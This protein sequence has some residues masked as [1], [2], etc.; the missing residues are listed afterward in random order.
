MTKKLSFITGLGLVLL[1]GL[2]LAGNLVFPA[3]GINFRWWEFW[4]LW[5]VIVISIG[6]L[7]C[8]GPFLSLGNRGLGGLFIPGIPI[9]VTGGI[10]AFCSIFDAWGAWAYLWPLEP[11]AL[12]LGFTFAAFWMRSVGLAFPAIIIGLNGLV[13]AFCNT[14]GWWQ[15]WTV[16]WTI[17]PLAIGLALLVVGV[18][19][20]HKALVAVGLGFCGFSAVAA[21]GMIVLILTGWWMFRYLWP[22][23]LI[24]TGV[25]VIL[26]G[27]IRPK[28]D[29]KPPPAQIDSEILPDGSGA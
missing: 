26:L 10:L 5:P 28:S 7:F 13:L 16:L 27:F 14:T 2:A 1:G 20:N 24:L 21:F 19:K 4:R 11:L 22:F 15:A 6:L 29:S 12:A 17:E 8:A 3:F 18:R 25:A 9:L 23:G